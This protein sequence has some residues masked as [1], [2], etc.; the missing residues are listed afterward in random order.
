MYVRRTI[1]MN[2]EVLIRFVVRSRFSRA[3]KVIKGL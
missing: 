1:Y 3:R 2:N